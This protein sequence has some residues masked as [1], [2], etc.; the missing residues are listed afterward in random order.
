M[1]LTKCDLKMLR[2]FQLLHINNSDILQLD[3]KS[4][5]LYSYKISIY[6]FYI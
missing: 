2:I 4:K 6:I 3:L 5:H 1:Y